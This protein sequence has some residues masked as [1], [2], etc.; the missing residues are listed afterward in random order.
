M[1]ETEVKVF[2]YSQDIFQ[3]ISYL[4]MHMALHSPPPLSVNSLQS[5]SHVQH[6]MTPWNA[7]PQAILSV[8]NS[9]N[10]LKQ[11]PS[12]QWCKSSVVPFPS[13]LP[14]FPASES[15]LMSQFF[16]SEVQ[17]IRVSALSSVLLRN[18]QDWFPS[19]W[20]GWISLQPKGLSRVFSNIT[21]Q[22]HQ[23]FGT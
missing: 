7:V 10:L 23:F 14:S 2:Q 12:S 21:V 17:S 8:T 1:E 9:W 13:C 3:Y 18:I 20:T 11:C 6:F 22:K 16:T 15:L 4:D 19:E 5:L